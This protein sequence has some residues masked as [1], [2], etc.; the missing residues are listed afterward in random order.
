MYAKMKIMSPVN[1]TKDQYTINSLNSIIMANFK[2]SI[3]GSYSG[4]IIFQA[5]V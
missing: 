4:Q 1:K 5:F 3:K 2:N